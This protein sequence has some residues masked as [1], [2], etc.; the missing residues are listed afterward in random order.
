M[1]SVMFVFLQ[2]TGSLKLCFMEIIQFL[3]IQSRAYVLQFHLPACSSGYLQLLGLTLWYAEKKTRAEVLITISKAFTYSL[4]K[5][6]RRRFGECRSPGVHL[7]SR[8]LKISWLSRAHYIQ[9]LPA[10][11][12]QEREWCF[13]FHTSQILTV[14][15]SES[16]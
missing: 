8:K 14:S 11:R 9:I 1:C 15:H 6:L 4:S 12:I 10:L 3:S 13:C 5:K 7:L 16:E 2:N